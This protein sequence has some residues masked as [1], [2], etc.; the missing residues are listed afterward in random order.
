MTASLFQ[1]TEGQAPLLIS[2]PHNGTKIPD[3][4]AACMTDIGLTV[5]DTDWYIDRLYDFASDVGAYV[6]KP[7]CN[8]LVIDLNRDPAGV[9]LYPGAQSTELCPTT[10][11]DFSP[12][13]K[14][15]QQPDEQ[16]VNRRIEQ[17]WR[18]YHQ[19]LEQALADIRD[20]FGVAVLLD[21]HSIRSEVARFF[22]GRLPDFNFGTASGQS[23]S[24][25][26]QEHLQQFDTGSYSQVSNGRFKGGYITRAYGDP[27]SNIHAV[28][29]ELSQ[30]T[31]MNEGNADYDERLAAQVKPVLREFVEHLLKF[32][33]QDK[34]AL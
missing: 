34:G 4:I 30:R 5:P 28:Q 1:Y 11:F 3:D 18:P 19:Q 9:N 21:A 17:Y 33:D 27:D 8:R 29:L 26:M 25:A 16:E 32:A 14:S 6:I 24:K 2:M 31:Y 20:R 7:T 23:C 13:Y 12:V 10:C 22:D 15:D